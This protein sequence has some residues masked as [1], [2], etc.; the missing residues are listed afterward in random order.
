MSN[1]S[2][3]RPISLYL[4]VTEATEAVNDGITTFFPRMHSVKNTSI[5]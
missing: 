3:T 2:R 1:K 4:V 5:I